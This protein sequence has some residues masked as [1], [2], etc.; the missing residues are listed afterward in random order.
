M[1]D[2]NEVTKKIINIMKVVFNID[3]NVEINDINNKKINNWDSLRHLSLIFAI[4]EEF[5]INFTDSEIQ[6]INDFETLYD[7]VSKRLT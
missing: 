4:E 6:S 7:I 5:N 2:K 3:N 1:I